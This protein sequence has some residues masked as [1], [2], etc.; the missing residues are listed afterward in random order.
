MYKTI[1]VMHPGYFYILFI[2]LCFL[3]VP[4]KS[5]KAAVYSI[6]SDQSLSED[7]VSYWKLDESSGNAQDSVSSNN[8]TNSNSVSYSSGLINNAADFGAS[9]VSGRNLSVASNL[10]I[11]ESNAFSISFWFKLNTELSLGEAYTLLNLEKGS[12]DGY[13]NIYY[14]DESGTKKIKTENGTPISYNFS[15]G[16]TTWHHVVLMKELGNTATSSLYIDGSLVGQGTSEISGGGSA[17]FH[18]GGNCC[19]VSSAAAKFDEMGVWNKA[20]SSDDVTNL[21]NQGKP[22]PYETPVFYTYQSLSDDLISY[23]KLD[24]S[25]GDAN[26]SVSSN[27]LT[28]SNG[29]A[30]GSGA[31]RGA[32]DFG[33]RISGRNLSISSNLGISSTDP[34]SLSFWFKV[35]TEPSSGQAYTIFNL[36]KGYSSG[37]ENLYYL[38]DGGVKKLRTEN[39]TVISYNF[40][41]GT[42][43]WHHVVFT[44]NSG[45]SASTNLYV[46]GTLVGQ[47]T[48]QVSGGGSPYFHFGG[49]CCGVYSSPILADELSAWKKS[50]SST[51]VSELYN[52]GTPLPYV[53]SAPTTTPSIYKNLVSYWKFDESS[54]NAQDSV[55]IYNLTNTNSVEYSSG[56]LNNA[57]D[58]GT[59]SVSG[60]HMATSSNLSIGDISAFSVSFWFKVN[61]SP[62]T[63]DVYTLMNLEK[64]SGAGYE[65]IYYVNEGGTTKLKTEN[66][67]PVSYNFNASSTWH[68]IVYTKE[69]GNSVTT[70]LYI[71]SNLVGQ[72]TSQVSGGGSPYFHIGGNCCSVSSAP[73]K[74]DE[75]G[76]WKKALNTQDVSDLYNSGTPLQYPW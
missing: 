74:L 7:L 44:K 70:S 37:Y 23:W 30:Y 15:A 52:S 18:V 34:Y 41:A 9:P 21:Y 4:I 27:T 24:E 14:V 50:L 64:G 48:S 25:S 71:D 19:G 39:G 65:N 55:S 49:N 51:E 40:I 76:V 29:V 36:E 10:G 35:S 46:D 13:E 33:T 12:D 20:L 26:D 38:N 66:G 61:T 16:T 11:G 42:T 8:L 22:V 75:F 58:F 45:G 72:G 28:N 3:V 31:L 43:T 32:A 73:V 60:R 47:G 59:T 54:G 62:Q 68:H 5:S 57:A 2:V 67:T 17:Y 1:K 6:K 56:A 63:G 53:S 69:L